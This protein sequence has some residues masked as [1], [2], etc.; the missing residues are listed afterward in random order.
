MPPDPVA[1]AVR[2]AVATDAEA[3][4]L[5][6][7][8]R[9]AADLGFVDYTIGDVRTDL[10][11]PD[12][13]VWVAEAGGAVAG[14]ALVDHRGASVSVHPDH[15]GRGIGT[16]LRHAV[17]RRMRGRGRPLRQFVAGGNEEARRLLARAGYRLAHEFLTLR[18]E[19]D[20]RAWGAG[21]G[22]A[23]IRAM[24]RPSEDERAHALVQAAMSEVEA[25]PPQGLADW[26]AELLDR[27]DFTHPTFLV[28]EAD[29]RMA[30]VLIG[31]EREGSGYVE[32]VA[33][34]PGSRRSGLGRALL[35]AAFERFASAGLPACELAVH[36]R[37]R[38]ALSLYESL[39]MREV[40][41]SERWEGPA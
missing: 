14:V 2:R 30:G 39:G 9:D 26:R 29:G 11:R 28:A 35:L 20:D 33:V 17:E 8:A 38:P 5:V 3:A 23:A 34:H 27:E 32:V 31:R 6:I 7:A 22:G 4:F 36:G 1:P 16:A 18:V 15:C 25:N 24:R 12:V 13:D 37:N 40:R 10:E 19:L 41:R 21:H